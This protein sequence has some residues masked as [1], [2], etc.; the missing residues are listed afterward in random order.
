M[1]A[2]GM[3]AGFTRDQIAA[4]AALAH[5]EL[6][7]SEIDLFARQLGEHPRIRRGRAAD[8]H[9]R[10]P[11]HR[12]GRR[13]AMRRIAPDEVPPS[14]D[15]DEALAAA[16][17]AALGRGLLPSAAGHPDDRSRSG[18]DATHS[19]VRRALGARDLPGGA[20]R[21]S[22][23]INPQLNAFNT[24]V[25]RPRDGARAAIDRDPDR[26]RDAPLA[27]V[28]IALKDNLCTARRPDHRLVAHARNTTCRHRRH[29]ASRGSSAR[30]RA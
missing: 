29:R 21:A 6:D 24:V 9:D 26:W 13:A 5:L 30:R 14:L 8:R 12:L 1:L 25:G 15:R 20:R 4:I 17:D 3:P 27:G 18:R 28:P 23:A 22:E 11:S 2:F 7:A 10:R 19:P 16:P